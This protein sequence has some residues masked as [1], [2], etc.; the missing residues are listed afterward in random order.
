MAATGIILC[1]FSTVVVNS[2]GAVLFSLL[3]LL[4][5]VV[6]YLL[7]VRVGHGER[8]Q[9]SFETKSHGRWV[10]PLMG[11]LLVIVFTQS[12]QTGSRWRSML[13]NVR[14]GFMITDSVN[15]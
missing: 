9:E 2:R 1:F 13:D 12:L 7:R 6:A 8:S 3:V 4:L 14:V 5:A 11:A 15:F 10:L